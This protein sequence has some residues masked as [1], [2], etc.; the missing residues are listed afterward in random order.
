LKASIA[1]FHI[2]PA[3]IFERKQLTVALALVV[4]PC[5]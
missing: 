3:D 4:P 1:W 2:R 5:L